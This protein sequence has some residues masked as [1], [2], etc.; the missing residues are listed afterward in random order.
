M[1]TPCNSAGRK[2]IG[3]PFGSRCDSMVLSDVQCLVLYCRLRPGCCACQ[4]T[5]CLADRCLQFFGHASRSADRT[6]YLRMHAPTRN[7]CTL[8]RL[9]FG[10]RYESG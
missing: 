2:I 8:A 1:Q 3:W 9:S 4:R 7:M 6:A 10:I 5:A